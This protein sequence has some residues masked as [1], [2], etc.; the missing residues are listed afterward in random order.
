[1][2]RPRYWQELFLNG[3]CYFDKDLY[4]NGEGDIIYNKFNY[5]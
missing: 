4:R 1:M 5:D 3:K 2:K